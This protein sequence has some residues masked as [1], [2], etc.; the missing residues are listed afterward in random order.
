[1]TRIKVLKKGKAIN[2]TFDTHHINMPKTENLTTKS[3]H[4]LV[5]GMDMAIR[6]WIGYYIIFFI[7]TV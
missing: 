3:I 7:S 5:L 4:K 2:F 1:M 6:L